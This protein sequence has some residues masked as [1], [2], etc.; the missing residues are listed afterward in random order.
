MESKVGKG[1]GKK[2][3][4]GGGGG[5]WSVKGLTGGKRNRG[6]P[7]GWD[8]GERRPSNFWYAMYSCSNANH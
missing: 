4:R 8:V 2:G 1:G 3:V 6:D 7:V 5:E